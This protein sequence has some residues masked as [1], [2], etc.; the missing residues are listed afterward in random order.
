MSGDAAPDEAAAIAARYAARDADV[1]ARRYSLFDAAALQAHQERQRAMLDLW[2]QH[3]W[4]DL[5]GRDLLEVGCGAGGN[6]LD[7]LRLGA[8]PVRVAGIEL[9]PERADAARARLP[10]AVH[11]ACADASRQGIAPAS[12]DAVLAFTVFSSVLDDA[13]RHALAAAVWQ[14]VRCGGGVLVYDFAVD[15]PANP[16]V[17]AL[18]HAQLLALFPQAAAVRGRRLT[19]APPVA[20][21][22]ARLSPRLLAPLSGLLPPLHT[23]RLWWLTKSFENQGTHL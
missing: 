8:E 7:L 20:R 2:R 19:L 11:I 4:H 6:L 15:N 22:L 9:L 21:R 18:R 10:A 5:A 12:V 16:S 17:R 14:G 13:A 3:G 1:D 23:H